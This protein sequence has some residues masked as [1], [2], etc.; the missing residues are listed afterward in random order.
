MTAQN[1]QD[2]PL[3]ELSRVLTPRDERRAQNRRIHNAQMEAGELGSSES[4]HRQY[5]AA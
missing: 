5:C 3:A 2:D 1:Q 4:F